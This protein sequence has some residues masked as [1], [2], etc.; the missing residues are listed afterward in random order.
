TPSLTLYHFPTSQSERIPFLLEE[1][2][3]PYTLIVHP[4]NPTFF[5]PPPLISKHPMGTAP[6]LE[7]FTLDP[8]N[9]IVLGESAAIAD[10]IIHRYGDGRLAL[11]PSEKEYPNYLYWFHF[12]NSTLQPLLARRIGIL[13]SDTSAKAKDSEERLHRMLRYFNQRVEENVWLAGGTF[14]A[15]DVM[16]LWCL[17]NMRKFSPVDLGEYKGI[18]GWLERCTEREGYRRAMEK[19]DP[20]LSVEEGRSAKGPEL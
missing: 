9:P 16:N 4:R 17:T 13:P 15:A 8:N 2:S 3:L 14:T 11:E 20:E 10:Y 5:A 6:L 1:L 7:D 19:C 18:L 12:A